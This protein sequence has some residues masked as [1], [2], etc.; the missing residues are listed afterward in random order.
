MPQLQ[1]EIYLVFIFQK[2]RQPV[3]L[4]LEVEGGLQ[5]WFLWETSRAYSTSTKANASQL[6][7]GPTTGLKAELIREGS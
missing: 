6:Y 1:K 2:K 3:V 7:N 4:S 5:R